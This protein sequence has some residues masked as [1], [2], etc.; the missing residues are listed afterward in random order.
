M[1]TSTSDFPK[2]V[3]A[4]LIANGKSVR[5]WAIEHGYRVSTV[6]AAL[7]ARRAGKLAKQI[8]SSL[9]KLIPHDNAV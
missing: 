7:H 3:R 8:R 6:Y 5:R 4:A 9:R 2:L 1:Q